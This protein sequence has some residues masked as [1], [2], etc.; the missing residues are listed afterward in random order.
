MDRG[1]AALAKDADAFHPAVLQLIAKTC[2]AANKH[3]K[4]V[5]V[6]GGL[7]SDS[8]ATALLIGLG[9]KELSASGNSIAHV[10]STVRSL[11]LAHCQALAKSALA[12]DSPQAVRELIQKMH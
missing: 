12:A 4:W 1:H 7:A 10:K 5:G 8:T 2:E 9:V 3:G 11:T 6:C